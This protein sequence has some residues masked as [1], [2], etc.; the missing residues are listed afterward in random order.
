MPKPSPINLNK[1][2]DV[3]A[4]T[5]EK[6]EERWLSDLSAYAVNASDP[7]RTITI[8]EPIGEQWDGSGF[9]L[10]RLDAAL[11]AMGEGPVTVA[12][13]SPGGN[14]FEG[15]GIYNRLHAHAGDVTVKVMGLAASAASVIAMAGDRVEMGEGSF[16]MIHNA[17]VIAAGNKT[18]LRETADWLDPFDAVMTTMYAERTGMEAGDI[19]ALM[20]AETWLTADDAIEQ[21][22][23]DAKLDK[24]E[25]GSRDKAK[26][27]AN[28]KRRLEAALAKTPNMSRR[29]AR[30]LINQISGAQPAAETDTPGAVEGTPG[31]AEPAFTALLATLRS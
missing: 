25:T 26:A 6:V 24:G 14:V 22:F 21:G 18:E 29:E 17:W 13:N 2:P 19:A 7:V 15:V 31:A 11:R 27:A 5:D 9:T 10:K 30:A 1:T 28:P 3:L 16:L 12:I 23:A 20:D 4:F 8:Y